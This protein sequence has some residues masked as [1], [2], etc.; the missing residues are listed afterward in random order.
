M[1]KLPDL[2]Y[3]Y[4]ALEPFIDEQTMRVHH[5][6]H[7][8]GY[9]DKF[10]QALSEYPEFQEKSAEELLRDLDV[11]PQEIRMAVKNNGG[12]YV[13]HSFFWPLL[14][15]NGGEPSGEILKLITNH[16]NQ[17]DEFRQQFSLAALNLFGS[18]WA[19]LV[20]DRG[21][22]EIVAT[23]NQDSPLSQG[24]TPL[25]ALD[26]WEHA[27]YLKYQNKRADYIEAFFNIINWDQV[28]KNL[29]AVGQ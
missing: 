25:L 9:T 1:Y 28:N 21:Q 7:H 27:Y 22:L 14:K 8:Q 5:D 4:D 11:I 20:V 26:V 29:E 12:G 2:P 3:A 6:K 16:F 15:K 23:Q 10:N 19:W 17:Y 18:G 24:K 13:N